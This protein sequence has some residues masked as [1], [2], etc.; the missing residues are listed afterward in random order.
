MNQNRTMQVRVEREKSQTAAV[1][2]ELEEAQQHIAHL[3][4]ALSSSSAGTG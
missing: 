3:K 2:A 4:N 1:R